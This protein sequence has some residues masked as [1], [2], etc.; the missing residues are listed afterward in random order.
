[1]GKRAVPGPL[2]TV[3]IPSRRFARLATQIGEYPGKTFT[4]FWRTALDQVTVSNLLPLQCTAWR[5]WP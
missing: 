2:L 4:R 1:M 5:R 3:D